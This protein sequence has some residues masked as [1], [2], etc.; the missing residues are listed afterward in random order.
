M[1]VILVPYRLGTNDPR[2]VKQ[3]DCE[4]SRAAQ[5]S[6]AWFVAPPDENVDG[7]VRVEV[8][9]DESNI[10]KT[11]EMAPQTAAR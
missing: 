10:A 5:T 9:N 8:G 4:A 7:S 3:Q 2:A 11:I 6:R 1:I